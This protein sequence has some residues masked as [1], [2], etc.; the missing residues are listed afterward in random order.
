MILLIITKIIGQGI[1]LTRKEAIHLEMNNWPG[2]RFI[3]DIPDPEGVP[4]P[5]PNYDRPAPFKLPGNKDDLKNPKDK[6]GKS[7]PEV[8]I[9]NPVA[10]NT[11]ILHPKTKEP[12]TCRPVID[13][14]D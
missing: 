7:L 6:T 11:P 5:N 8:P 12:L 10:D 3:R 9:L 1:N 13:E 4:G 2:D 14:N